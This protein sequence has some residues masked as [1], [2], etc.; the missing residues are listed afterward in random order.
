MNVDSTLAVANVP[1][2]FHDGH[3]HRDKHTTNN[4]SQTQVT[5]NKRPASEMEEQ[6]ARARKQ[7]LY[8]GNYPETH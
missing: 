5:I 1:I 3:H 4:D 8:P 7:A 6:E 2:A